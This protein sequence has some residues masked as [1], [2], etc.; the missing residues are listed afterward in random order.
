MLNITNLLPINDF[1][2]EE[3]SIIFSNI[4]QCSSICQ[5]DENTVVFGS[6]NIRVKFKKDASRILEITAQKEFWKT[7]KKQIIDTF[8]KAATP[9]KFKIYSR[10]VFTSGR[11][12]L[13]PP[14][15]WRDDFQLGRIPS[16]NPKA[17]DY[18][19]KQPSLFQFK[20]AV[21]DIP[22]LDAYRAEKKFQATFLP[23][24]PIFRQ[25]CT[26]DL[27]CDMNSTIGFDWALSETEGGY[28]SSFSQLG[29]HLESSLS[30]QDWHAYSQPEIKHLPIEGMDFYWLSASSVSTTYQAYEQ[31]SEE[32]KDLF[33]LGCE[34]FVKSITARNSTDK[35]LFMM[36]MLEIFL[37]NESSSCGE[38]GQPKFGINQ[39]FKTYI[40][41]VIGERW[42][43]NFTKIL[44][45][46]YSLRSK[47]A[48]QGMAVAQ[49]T[50]SLIPA[51]CREDSQVRYLVE[52]GRQFLV[53]W[54][55]RKQSKD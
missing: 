14:F 13:F 29:Y 4:A 35:F 28:T 34:W 47:I 30:K 11:E 23:L 44:S 31:L 22:F 24:V 9:N 20:V 42:T 51:S 16:G 36:I 15:R 32:D 6:G 41:E 26:T 45:D 7:H 21:C 37:P 52:L 40:P 55:F 46:L 39:K 49:H 27:H 43:I 3:V 25:H 17:G 33:L 2:I 38:C 48:H 5:T 54:L 18:C 50:S 12:V 53:S 8:K 19:P 1:S 10:V